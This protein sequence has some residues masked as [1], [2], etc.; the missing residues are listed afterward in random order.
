MLSVSNLL[1]KNADLLQLIYYRQEITSAE[2][3]LLLKKSIP[4]V[5]KQFTELTDAGF[6]IEKGV[7]VSSG[8]RRP[9]MYCPVAGALFFVSVAIN[10]RRSEIGI[11]NF[12]N[13]LIKDSV[14]LAASLEPNDLLVLDNLADKINAEI[15]DSGIDKSKVVGVAFGMPGFIDIG[16]GINH[17][18]FSDDLDLR[19]YLSDKLELPVLIDND[20]SL[21]ALAELKFGKDGQ[22]D[23]MVVN[24]GWGIGLGMILNGEMFRGHSGMAG[25]FSHIPLFNDGL[26]CSCGKRDCLETQSSL[27]FIEKKARKLSAQANVV[28]TLPAGTEITVEDVFSNAHRGDNFCIK[29]ISEAA[30]NI[31]RG[32][33]TL[34]HIINPEYIILSGYGAS[35]GNMWMASVQQAINEH[36]ILRIAD[37][38]TL[39]LSELGKTAGL[40]GGTALLMENIS[41]LIK[42]AEIEL[43]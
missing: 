17:T 2:A 5:N 6:I 32:L 28:T 42:P 10:Q 24:I 15:N 20:S 12:K 31:G 39:Q 26:L 25:E 14:V 37:K 16:K 34:I 1:E 4:S 21:I 43:N 30:Y 38:T 7:A 13:E 19:E 8:G 9:V 29:L 33:A 11:Y 36:S 27:S 23:V 41:T 18:F 3:S 40:L 35:L 22:T